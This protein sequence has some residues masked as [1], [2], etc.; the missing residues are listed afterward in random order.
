MVSEDVP[1]TRFA[2]FL[3]FEP[4]LHDMSDVVWG[5]KCADKQKGE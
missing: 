1:F 3:M 2:G 5:G 4:P